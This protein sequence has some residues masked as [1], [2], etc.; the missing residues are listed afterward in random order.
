MLVSKKQIVS[1]KVSI[2]S[3]NGKKYKNAEV[4]LHEASTY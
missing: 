4:F 3:Y 1:I 2:N